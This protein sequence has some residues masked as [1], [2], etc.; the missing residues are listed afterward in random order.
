MLEQDTI[1]STQ[2][3]D[4]ANILFFISLLSPYYQ[5]NLFYHA[6]GFSDDRSFLFFGAKANTTNTVANTNAI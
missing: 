6:Y 5:L 4:N 1:A 3:S 2:T